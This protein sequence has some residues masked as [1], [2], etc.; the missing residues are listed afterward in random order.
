MT[1]FLWCSVHK[2]TAEQTE[3]LL[4]K[5]KLYF[6]VD[7]DPAMQDSLNNCPANRAELSRLAVDLSYKA[8]EYTIVQPGGSPIFQF[9]L[10]LVAEQAGID[11]S[12][13]YAHSE[14][15]SIDTPQSDGTV[16]KTSV[17]KHLGFI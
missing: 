7:I 9:M 5:G 2:P 8:G 12:I 11:A 13:L 3:E 4:A 14:R 1:K 15:V 6:L 17:F 10:G 16:V